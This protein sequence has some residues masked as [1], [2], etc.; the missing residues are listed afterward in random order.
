VAA[1][2]PGRGRSRDFVALLLSVAS[3]VLVGLF[4]VVIPWT[5]AWDTNGVLQGAPRLQ[6]LVLSGTFRGIV[7]G[8]GVVNIL[9]ALHDLLEGEPLAG[10]HD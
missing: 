1:A 9:L 6:A 4:L 3:F 5:A 10:S 7:S 8:L 2:H